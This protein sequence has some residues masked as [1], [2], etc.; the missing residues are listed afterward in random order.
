[1]VPAFLHRLGLDPSADERAI[2]RAYA[3]KL[4]RIDQETDPTAF[5]ALREDYE[6]ALNWVRRLAQA[7]QQSEPS[8]AGASSGSSRAEAQQDEAQDAPVQSYAPPK[9][10][11]QLRRPASPPA[12][13]NPRTDAS[14]ETAAAFAR[15]YDAFA[16]EAGQASSRLDAH[17]WQAKLEEVLASD[18]L[19]SLAA[20]D[21][22]E[23]HMASLL[24]RGWK[25]G[26]EVLFVVAV[27][28][29][30][31]E[32]DARHARRLGQAG[33]AIE[34][35]L[36][37]RAVFDRQDSNIRARQRIVIQRLRDPADPTRKELASSFLTLEQ[38]VASFPTWLAIV[39][40]LGHLARWRALFAALP[41][42]LQEGAKR[43]AK[44]RTKTKTNTKT[45]QGSSFKVRWV[46]LS[47]IMLS[48]FVR[49]LN[50]PSSRPPA[51][52]AEAQQT[53]RMLAEQQQK[54]PLPFSPPPNA[55]PAASTVPVMPAANTASGNRSSSKPLDKR[56]I[57]KL[58]AK[59]PTEAV[60]NEIFLISVDHAIGTS[61]QDCDPGPQFD[62]QIVACVAKQR[63]P[64]PSFNDPAVEQALSREKIRL[65]ST[66]KQPKISLVDPI[67]LPPKPYRP[68]V[69]TLTPPDAG[70]RPSGT[71]SAA[72]PA[73]PGDGSE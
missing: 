62:R 67:A 44:S 53:M 34:R 30:R 13:A 11:P 22:F 60:C 16:H 21:L 27:N 33:T 55:R 18:T 65:A 40:D 54:L 43:P 58:V 36:F 25:R 2:R 4:K 23:L 37:E 71:P 12:A 59:P 42:R 17:E 26:H 29:F 32:E 72:S 46:F 1:M 14:T 47:M 35:A 24:A 56:A 20:H 7:S 39:T 31:W 38:V 52:P 70:N 68:P 6:A 19:V 61:E 15:F 8:N 48:A 49:L 51:A 3:Q 64:R 63:W 5:Q 66:A 57:A 41:V 73:P 28:V 10:M 69:F 50:S 45:S 9:V